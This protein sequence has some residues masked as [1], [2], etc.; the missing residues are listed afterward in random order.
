MKSF[1]TLLLSALLLAAAG[2]LYL[3]WSHQAAFPSTDDATLR[4]DILIIVPQVSGRAESVTAVE[5]GY[6]KTGDVLFTL[7]RS[8]L[9][10][11]VDTAPAQLELARLSTEAL[12]S[13][14]AAAQATVT[15][16]A[17]ALRQRQRQRQRQRPIWPAAPP[18]SRPAMWRRWPLGRRRPRAIRPR[19][20]RP[21]RTLLWRPPRIRQAQA[22]PRASKPLRAFWIRPNLPCRMPQ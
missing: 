9:Q 17:A 14:V 12:T 1:K 20:P 21:R 18:S 8:A 10:A 4:A 11:A 13:E 2:G 3:W 19:R 22:V 5:N 6:V 16:A 7:D 15:S